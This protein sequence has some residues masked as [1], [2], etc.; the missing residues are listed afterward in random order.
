MTTRNVDTVEIEIPGIG[1][2]L[3]AVPSR[4]GSDKQIWKLY[5]ATDSAGKIKM[6]Y[7]F[8]PD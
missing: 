3:E 5:Q 8:P 7:Y 1:F 2:E 6:L 4:R